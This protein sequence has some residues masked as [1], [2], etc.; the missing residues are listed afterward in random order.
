[1]DRAIT[2]AAPTRIAA[3]PQVGNGAWV[4]DYLVPPVVVTAALWW[5]QLWPV[6]PVQ[7]GLGFALLC[8]PW[9]SYVHWKHSG[10]KRFPLYTIIAFVYWLFYAVPLFWGDRFAPVVGHVQ[11][12]SNASITG[13]MIMANLGM[14]ALWL[15]MHSS[16]GR[17]MRLPRIADVSLTDRNLTYIRLILAL[18]TVY[19]LFPDL[20]TGASASIR[21]VVLTLQVSVPLL[22]YVIL[23]RRIIGGTR[24]RADL[25]LTVAY[26]LIS[27]GVGISHGVLGPALSPVF[28]A[29][30]LYLWERRRFPVTPI[31]I[32]FA[33]IL[34]FQPTKNVFR[35]QFGDLGTG[36][37]TAAAYSNPLAKASSWIESS[38]SAWEGALTSPNSGEA[39]T[40][41]R[42]TVLRV[43][44]LTQTAHILDWTPGEV[45]FQH[46][47]TYT[48]LVAGYVPRALWPDKPSVN[49]ANRFY[50]V[51]YDL[52]FANQ[53]DT[54][55]VSSGS[56]AEGYINF[57]WPGAVI[58]MF[59]LGL[60]FDFVVA[61]FLSSSS[62]Q[63]FTALGL[64]FVMQFIVIESQLAVYLS[65]LLETTLILVI[66]F[67]PVLHREHS[68]KTQATS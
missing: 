10:D 23:V 7:A 15:G 20:A 58:V 6:S 34:F 13:S 8:F 3:R 39:L 48:Y 28:A 41:V 56:L 21:Q 33:L 49:D 11:Y 54:V 5:T 53:L 22:A 18:T 17:H 66:V 52:T 57:S 55:S 46:G 60:L 27:L 25:V 16:I 51:A 62:G 9:W 64:V 2:P 36:Q 47:S 67:F 31:L 19:A 50:Q 43:S 61:T 32:G 68:A 26:A 35:Q 30:L 29:V 12:V 40:L 63:F 42:S 14:V 24:T 44:L 45:S 65:G 4:R 59:L 1:M 37:T 38:F